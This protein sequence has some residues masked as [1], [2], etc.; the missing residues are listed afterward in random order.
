MK[1][2]LMIMLGAAVLGTVCCS[3]MTADKVSAKT[4]GDYKYVVTG[5]KK[6]TCA[7]RKYT[8]KEK[9]VTV[10][11]KLDGYT[12]TRIGNQAFKSNKNIKSVKLPK[13]IT[14]IGNYS[15]S[16][17]SN[18]ES[19]TLSPKVH[20]IKWNAFSSCKKLKNLSLSSTLKKIG[21]YAFSNCRSL[22]D[23][24]LPDSVETI[25]FNAF[26]GCKLTS[27]YIPKDLGETDL[28]SV[29]ELGSVT[30]ITVADGN[31]YYD[32]RDNC[33]AIIETATNRLILATNDSSIP[34]SISAI[35]SGA[36]SGC[37]AIKEIIIPA[38]VTT[39]EFDAFYGC[40]G[41]EKVNLPKGLK[42]I[43]SEAFC[44]CSSL[45]EIKIP[46]SVSAIGSEAFSGCEAIKEITIPASV[47]SIEDSTFYS[48]SGLEKVDLS[49]GLSSIGNEAFSCCTSLKEIRLPDS[50]ETIGEDAFYDCS[51]IENIYIP[52]NLGETDLPLV[53]DCESAAKITVAD[54]NKF[55]DSRNNCNAVI[56][57]D[58]D[59]L[60][61]A[62]KNTLIPNSVKIIDKNAFL[63][64]PSEITVPEGVEI[65]YDFAFIG[66]DSLKTV[67]LPVSLTELGDDAFDCSMETINYRG[68]KK[69]W[70]MIKTAIKETDGN[71]CDDEMYH[72]KINYN[73]QG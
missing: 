11:D 39:I 30:K 71:E 61:L 69:Q 9:D 35:G 16:K 70:E 1:K 53:F 44:K 26:R 62:C 72:I 55:Y 13:H 42:T 66:N 41:L 60:A 36:F 34:D 27:I 8:G 4:S 5:K 45:K 68:S 18:L 32:S 12:V 6:K 67:T 24:K 64:T 50:V 25:G 33:N 73:Y 38:S 43:G 51:K 7:I 58:S 21:N 59:T 19:I 3:N 52:K 65:I 40:S 20:T 15:F 2:G 56:E 28:S 31:K 48:C 47:S 14:V 29:F 10:P 49:E 57:K 37:D 46:D 22:Q 17:C 23:I 54:G 63:N